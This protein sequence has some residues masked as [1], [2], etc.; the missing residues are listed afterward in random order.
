MDSSFVN[1]TKKMC[2]LNITSESISFSD[3]SGKIER[4]KPNVFIGEFEKDL[5]TISTHEAVDFSYHYLTS[6]LYNKSETSSD[7]YLNF[8]YIEKLGKLEVF[9]DEC[10]CYVIFK[11]N[12]KE[13][14]IYLYQIL[15][16]LFPI[17]DS[18]KIYLLVPYFWKKRECTL[19]EK[20]HMNNV[21]FVP[22]LYTNL[23]HQN[24]QN[25]FLIYIKV[26]HSDCEFLIYDGRKK[27]DNFDERI[28]YSASLTIGLINMVDCLAHR[29][30]DKFD[31][32]IC[33]SDVDKYSE[34][35]EAFN[36]ET[37]DK[38]FFHKIYSS[39]E[40]AIPLYSNSTPI[41]INFEDFCLYEV[42]Y[43]MYS[44]ACADVFEL[45]EREVI[46]LCVEAREYCDSSGTDLANVSVFL[47]GILYQDPV[48][49]G[50]VSVYFD[51]IDIKA[52]YLSSQTYF[53]NIVDC[54]R[55][56][57]ELFDLFS[58]SYVNKSISLTNQKWYMRE[59]ICVSVLEF[60]QRQISV[61]SPS[62]QVNL[63]LKYVSSVIEKFEP[64]SVLSETR[65]AI[66]RRIKDRGIKSGIQRK[67]IV[68]NPYIFFKPS[69]FNSENFD[70]LVGLYGL[71][72]VS[73]I[74]EELKA[75]G[76]TTIYPDFVNLYI[77]L[78][79][80]KPDCDFLYTNIASLSK[81]FPVVKPLTEKLRILLGK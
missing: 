35:V 75:Y 2:I 18:H 34:A 80:K 21:V 41:N 9:Y 4:R 64:G 66:K 46:N 23:Y 48:I 10:P 14:K 20:L 22:T 12:N 29:L 55:G 31:S 13:F 33:C 8:D 25:R 39:I 32:S 44:D 71:F 72:I 36:S 42:S 76:L 3:S 81:A 26:G 11:Y 68:R 15:K 49:E 54:F 7:N 53:E 24:M 56:K 69:R 77:H 28:V 67:K 65:S 74:S 43:D 38:K 45:I 59:H 60:I 52:S 78:L 16:W 51:D 27:S 79:T 37:V 62:D 50:F 1:D 19:Q 70:Y 6:L 58:S 30:F 40:A 47:D 5:I 61:Q 57:Y 17:E 63:M 73:K